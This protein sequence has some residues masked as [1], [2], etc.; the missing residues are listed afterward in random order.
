MYQ[1]LHQQVV[2]FYD[3]MKRNTFTA[4]LLLEIIQQDDKCSCSSLWVA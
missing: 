4:D 2:G 3:M 1:P